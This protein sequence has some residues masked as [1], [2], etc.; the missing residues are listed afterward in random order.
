M[1]ETIVEIRG[2]HL[3]TLRQNKSTQELPCGYAAMQVNPVVFLD[4]TAA[5]D[6]LAIFYLHTQ[7][8]GAE[9]GD[10]KR[11]TQ[12]VARGLLDIVG[13]IAVGRGFGYSV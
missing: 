6:Q 4:L 10:C 5:D 7:L 11:D 9:T 3:Y 2:Y 12:A 13:R 1:K 8:V